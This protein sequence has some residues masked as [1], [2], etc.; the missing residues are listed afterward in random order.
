MQLERGEMEV[1]GW[2][3]VQVGVGILGLQVN[4]HYEELVWPEE[5]QRLFLL[6]GWAGP[7]QEV[8]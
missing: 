7:R 4:L 2:V 1:V 3:E 6:M 5:N 8:E